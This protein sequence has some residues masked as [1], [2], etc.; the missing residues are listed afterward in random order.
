MESRVAGTLPEKDPEAAKRREEEERE[1]A[2]KWAQLEAYFKLEQEKCSELT[3]NKQE[4]VMIPSRFSHQGNSDEVEGL[5]PTIIM[6]KQQVA[7]PQQPQKGK[8]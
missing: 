7:E 4:F 6:R 5:C 3:W 2:A 8:Q 1:V